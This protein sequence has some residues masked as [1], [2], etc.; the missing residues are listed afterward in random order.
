MSE[1]YL[2]FTGRPNAGKSSLIRSITGIKTTSGK[3]PGTTRRIMFYSLNEG[4]TVADMPGYGRITGVRK[5]I[6]DQVKDQIIEFIEGEAERIAL[7]VHVL[8]A[9]TF[10]EITERL[11]RKGFISIDIEMTKLLFVNIGAPPLIA[12]NKID[13]T[14]GEGLDASLESLVRELGEDVPSVVGENIFPVSARTGEGL[15]ELKNA[16]H[17]RLVEKGYR[18]PFRLA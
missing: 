18:T 9:S 6:E 4:L 3:R 7:A 11:D 10:Q 12:A 5:G 2:V 13:K 17:E 1:R 14:T 16:I 15:G 8:D